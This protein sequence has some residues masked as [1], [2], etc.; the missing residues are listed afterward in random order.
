MREGVW[1]EVAK[2]AADIENM[3]VTPNTVAAYHRFYGISECEIKIWKP[4]GERTY[5]EAMNHPSEWQRDHWL[6]AFQ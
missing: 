3:L 6:S 2:R 4:F 1:V 5:D